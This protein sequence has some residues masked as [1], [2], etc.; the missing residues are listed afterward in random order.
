MQTIRRFKADVFQV[1]ANPTRIHI[2]EC[3]RDG[4]LSVGSIVERTGVEPANVSQ[5]LAMLR[6]KGL[7]VKRKVGN[8][9]FYALR[10]PLLY[11]VLDTMKRY[12]RAHLEEATE[13]LKRMEA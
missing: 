9:A 2:V 5:H 13:M 7:V 1:L 8:Q 12:F 10:D 6:T 3:L 11:E 4:E